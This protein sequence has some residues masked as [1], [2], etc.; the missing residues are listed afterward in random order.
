MKEYSIIKA[1]LKANRD[2]SAWGKGVNLYA[3]ELLESIQENL[4]YIGK[5]I[6]EFESKQEFE[7][8]ALNGARTWKDYSFGGC[9]LI[10]NWEICER[11][12][13]P[14]IIKKKQG[15]ALDPNRDELWMDV[16]TRALYQAFNRLWKASK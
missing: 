4:E 3:L 8:F 9:S 5:S 7:E 12:C 1:T 10:Y 15:G 14:S 2:R 11:L 6:T 13:P 16:Q